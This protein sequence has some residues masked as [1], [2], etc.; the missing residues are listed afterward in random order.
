MRVPDAGRVRRRWGGGSAEV[1]TPGDPG[2]R[3]TPAPEMT[4]SL[5]GRTVFIGGVLGLAVMPAPSPQGD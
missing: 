5:D 4:I 1:E 3:S 2:L